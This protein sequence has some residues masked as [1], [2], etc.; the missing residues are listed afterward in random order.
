MTCIVL[1]GTIAPSPDITHLYVRDPLERY[2]Q[3]IGNI[4]RW[5]TETNI[6]TI[7]FGENSNYTIHD[8][9][10]LQNLAAFYNK[11]LEIIQFV[12]DVEQTVK[13]GRWYGEQ[14]ILDYVIKHSKLIEDENV[15]YK[16]TGRY[17]IENINTILSQEEDKENVF[18]LISPLDRRC[19]TAFFKCSKKIFCTH[20]VW[21]GGYVNDNLW[22]DY[23]LEWVYK[24]I[25]NPIKKHIAC[26]K[27]LP[28][29][30]ADTWSGYKLRKHIL[31]DLCKQ[32]LHVL[33]L[34]KI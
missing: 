8:I 32:C 22:I 23:Q 18:S 2:R 11:K 26:F 34:Y 4:C 6:D 20:F 25:L 29:F 13:L 27:T 3:Y 19:N 17:W 21:C 10:A 14:E 9:Q 31:K 16:I 24:N 15:F 1:T 28:Q 7:I 5:I 33:G 30:S 12:W